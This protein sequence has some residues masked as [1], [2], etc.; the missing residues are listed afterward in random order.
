[1]DQI[2]ISPGFGPLRLAPLVNKLILKVKEVDNHM[3]MASAW[4]WEM[5]QVQF[6]NYHC[7]WLVSL[8]I[9]SAV[10][11]L[12]FNAFDLHCVVRDLKCKLLTGGELGRHHEGTI[13]PPSLRVA[14]VYD[15][16][17]RSYLIKLTR[18]D[19]KYYLYVDNGTRIHLQSKIKQNKSSVRLPSVF[20]LKVIGW[21]K[22]LP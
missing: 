19:E 6:K 9:H 5:N 7:N 22:S 3:E 14:N 16:G 8:L 10:M 12:R 18:T 17:P 21:S 11:S 13:V 2:S 15:F 4:G 1:M 20:C